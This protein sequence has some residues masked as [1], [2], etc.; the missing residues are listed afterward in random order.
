MTATAVATMP[1]RV[2]AGFAG[3]SRRLGVLFSAMPPL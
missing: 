2:K 3:R 1:A